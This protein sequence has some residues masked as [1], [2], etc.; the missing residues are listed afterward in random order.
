MHKFNK[1]VYFF[2]KRFLHD[3]KLPTVTTFLKTT[4]PL[5]GTQSPRKADF[6]KK[7][8]FKHKEYLYGHFNNLDEVVKA[9]RKLNKENN[10]HK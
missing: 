5:V 6:S 3:S 2:S 7:Y 8:T 1:S 10:K 4:V 9:R